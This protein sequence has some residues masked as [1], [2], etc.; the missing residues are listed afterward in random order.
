MSSLKKSIYLLLFAFAFPIA[1]F[2]QDVTVSL[3]HV[4]VDGYTND[5]V[6]PVTLTNPDSTVGGIQFDIIVMPEMLE[7]S[8]IT[9]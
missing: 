3:G 4:E 9:P 6:V 2:G 8:G 7:M 5:I 1:V